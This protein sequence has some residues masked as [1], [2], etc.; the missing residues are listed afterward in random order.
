V[1][2]IERAVDAGLELGRDAR[3]AAQEQLREVVAGV[4]DAA[5]AAGERQVRHVP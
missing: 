3:R 2:L 4:E 5:L 1:I